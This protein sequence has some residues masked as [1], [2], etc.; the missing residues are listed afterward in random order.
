MQHVCIN[1]AH[2]LGD[3]DYPTRLDVD[4]DDGTQGVYVNAATVQPMLNEQKELITTLRADNAR[5]RGELGEH[6]EAGCTCLKCRCR[7]A[8]IEAKDCAKL[9]G[10]TADQLQRYEVVVE[11]ARHIVIAWGVTHWV[12]PE[13]KAIE[14]ALAALE[15]SRDA[16]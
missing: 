4:Y 9:L 10:E 3:E 6:T 11:A 7:R 12:E 16:D 5:L 13:V 8:E 1:Q 15:V 14:Q 2:H